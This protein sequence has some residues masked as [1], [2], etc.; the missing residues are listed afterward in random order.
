M[1]PYAEV[2]FGSNQIQMRSDE[3]WNSL[4]HSFLFLL[5]WSN[6]VFLT[7]WIKAVRR[8]CLSFLRFMLKTTKTLQCIKLAFV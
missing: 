8:D 5:L 7:G 2:S 1:K 6:G 4:A 3:L